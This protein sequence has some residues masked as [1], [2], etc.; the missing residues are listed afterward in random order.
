MF[1]TYRAA[2]GSQT[3]V[4]GHNVRTVLYMRFVVNELKH[5]ETAASSF[6][7]NDVCPSV[8]T[9]GYHEHYV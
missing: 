7:G 9:P 6:K 8:P 4:V 5:A 1:L 3:R 2:I